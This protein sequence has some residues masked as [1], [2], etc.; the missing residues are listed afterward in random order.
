M[1]RKNAPRLSA[2]TAALTILLSLTSCASAP[3]VVSGDT[4]CERSRRIVATRDQ[5]DELLSNETKWRSL[6][7]QI[8]DHNDSYVMNCII[9][10]LIK[11][12]K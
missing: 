6:V 5:A 8:A 3:P 9:P 12:A 11:E 2:A 7:K 10:D 4:Y 1:L